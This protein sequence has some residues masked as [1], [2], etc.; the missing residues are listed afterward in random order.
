MS[1]VALILLL[2]TQS[3][4]RANFNLDSWVLGW[5]CGGCVA[6]AAGGDSC[7]PR[8]PVPVTSSP[9]P[10]LPQSIVL[11]ISKYTFKYNR[12]TERQWAADTWH[13]ARSCYL[14]SR[15]QLSG[16]A[17]LQPRVTRVTRV[18]LHS[19]SHFRLSNKSTGNP[20]FRADTLLHLPT[21]LTTL[22]H[23]SIIS[24]INIS[25]VQYSHY[26]PPQLLI[27]IGSTIQNL[28]HRTTHQPLK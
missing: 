26:F 17:S 7:C 2:L 20:S 13:V 18:T 10:P 24:M 22:H 11:L 4:Y 8:R 27:A 5:L 19:L 14:A 1:S 9:P 15:C 28:I 25:I 3:T 21:S 12:S 16:S 6:P 23:P